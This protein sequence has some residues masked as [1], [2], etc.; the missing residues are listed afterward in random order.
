MTP[1]AEALTVR[2]HHSFVA[3][4]ET[5]LTPRVYDPR[6]GLIG[7]SY[8]DYASPISEPLMKHFIIR[9]RLEKHDPVQPIVYYLD[10]GAPELPFVPRCSMAHVGGRRPSKQRVSAMPSASKFFRTMPTRWISATT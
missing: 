8:A 3:L 9:H 5:P 6:S 2:E 7:M 4:P 1:T 10:P